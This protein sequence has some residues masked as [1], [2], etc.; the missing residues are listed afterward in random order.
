MSDEKYT[1]LVI[2]GGGVRGITML[3]ALE[4]FY[5]QRQL[6]ATQLS[7]CAGSS[8][9]AILAFL[10]ICGY[11]PKELL[12]QA[13]FMGN[14]FA[15]TDISSISSLFQNWGFIDPSSFFLKIEKLIKTVPKDCCFIDLYKKRKIH[16]V[17][18][19]CNL[20]TGKIEYLD[21]KN[22]PNMKIID[23]LRISCSLPLIFTKAE[24]NKNL[25]LDGGLLNNIPMSIVPDELK[26]NTLVVYNDP[27]M[28]ECADF[29]M[30][31]YIVRFMQLS[32]SEITRLNIEKHGKDFR[33]LIPITSSAD[34]TPI[35]SKDDAQKKEMFDRG[36]ELAFTKSWDL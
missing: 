1:G 34:S 29:T 35:E 5:N 10:L 22:T 16:F 28:E 21:Y 9:G 11:Q 30:V 3:G 13:I 6:D 4:Y 15:A 19:G 23:A 2:G 8:I 32:I 27:N 18:T 26:K 36:Y 31:S 7:F 20:S 24:Y 14:W 33:Q 12:D 17:V 25:Y